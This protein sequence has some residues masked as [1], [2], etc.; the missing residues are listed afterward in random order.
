MPHFNPRKCRAIYLM[1]LIVPN[2][3]PTQRPTVPPII[4]PIFILSNV[5]GSMNCELFC[6][7]ETRER[8]PK[9][10]AINFPSHRQTQP[11]IKLPGPYELTLAVEPSRPRSAV[12]PTLTPLSQSQCSTSEHS[13]LNIFYESRKAHKEYFCMYSFNFA[14]STDFG[15]LICF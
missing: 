4:A 12:P 6:V 10:N 5:V 14:I 3:R 15:S 13:N 1:I 11:G 7:D 9:R 8:A 2:T